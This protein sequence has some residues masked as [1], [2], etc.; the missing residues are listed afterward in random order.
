M[1]YE[2]NNYLAHHGVKGMRWGHRKD[3]EDSKEDNKEK[4]SDGER[5]IDYIELKNGKKIQMEPY[6]MYKYLKTGKEVGAHLKDIGSMHNISYK[7][8]SGD[9]ELQKRMKSCV[10][11]YNN[12]AKKYGKMKYK[13]I[14][15]RQLRRE[16][17]AIDSESG[18]II[19]EY[20]RKH[21]GRIATY[22]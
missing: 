22:G 21:G 11:A 1:T 14:D 12:L 15:F 18:K 10:D 6:G 4:K 2:Y 16:T 19:T 17:N 20:Y 13:D 8:M 7:S 5:D 3:P 9:K